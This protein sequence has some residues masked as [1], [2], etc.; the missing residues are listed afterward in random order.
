MIKTT[1]LSLVLLSA[2]T[3]AS[4]SSL[5]AAEFGPGRSQMIPVGGGE[6]VLD[7]PAKQVALRFTAERDGP[8]TSIKFA[9]RVGL[10]GTVPTPKQFT[11]TLVE[12]NAG[13]PGKPVAMVVSEAAPTVAGARAREVIFRNALLKAGRVYQLVISMA[14]ASATKQMSVNYYLF[15]G[16]TPP[17][18]SFDMETPAP[19]SGVMTSM[20][21]GV[22]WNPV[23]TNAVGSMAIVVNGRLQ[24]WAYTGAYDARLFNTTAGERQV[25]MQ[26]F[27]FTTTGKGTSGKVNSIRFQLRAAG[28]LA[29]QPMPVRVRLLEGLRLKEVISVTQQIT[30][31]D[32]SRFFLVEVPLKDV[33]LKEGGDY[34]LSID[35]PQPTGD[36]AKDFLFIRTLSWGFGDPSLVDVGWQGAE[37]AMI[38]SPTEDNAGGITVTKVDIPFVID[39]TPVR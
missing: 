3:F 4:V 28:G 20:D 25:L 23:A 6:V 8:L 2:L 14:D 11:A 35:M 19:G 36:S 27:K 24:G 30:T 16:R 26:T 7:A 38:Q 37:G 10:L 22:T 5:S 12:D 39:Y 1:C 17:L 29:A 21:G 18:N 13:K 31:D 34:A 9:S 15:D 32:A 33:I